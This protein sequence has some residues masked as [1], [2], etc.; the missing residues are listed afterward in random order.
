MTAPVLHLDSNYIGFLDS[1][2]TK[3]KRAQIRAALSINKELILL[4]WTIGSE[5]IS[6]Q[7]QFKWGTQFIEQFSHD[8]QQAFPEMQGFSASNLK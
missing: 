7:Q 6:K 5:L 2:K 4:Y 8:M 3:F 1:I